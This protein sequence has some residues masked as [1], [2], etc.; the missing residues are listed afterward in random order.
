MVFL[1]EGGD[2]S[3]FTAEVAM[4]REGVDRSRFCTLTAKRFI[5]RGSYFIVGIN[6]VVN[7]EIRFFIPWKNQHTVSE[8]TNGR[9]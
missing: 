3:P 7:K 5:T 4:T 9:S 2:K 6:V 1:D 8:Q